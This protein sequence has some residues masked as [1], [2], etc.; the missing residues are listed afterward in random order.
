VLAF[1][2]GGGESG[3]VGGWVGAGTIFIIVIALKLI[4]VL[5]LVGA[6]RVQ[7]QPPRPDELASAYGKGLMARSCFDFGLQIYRV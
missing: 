7:C 1:Q 4:V 3:W 2:A 6:P 5:V